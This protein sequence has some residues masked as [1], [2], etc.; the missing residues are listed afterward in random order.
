[1]VYN[2]SN[3]EVSFASGVWCSQEDFYLACALMILENKLLLAPFPGNG[4]RK[5]FGGMFAVWAFAPGLPQSSWSLFSCV[6]LRHTGNEYD[7]SVPCFKA[8]GGEFP[9]R[10][11]YQAFDTLASFSPITHLLL[12]TDRCW[13]QRSAC[14]LSLVGLVD[15]KEYQDMM[16]EALNKEICCH[17]GLW[18][19]GPWMSLLSPWT[20]P[21]F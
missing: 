9:Q 6:C 12:T 2:L 18:G 17:H 7:L 11:Y 10:M 15:S 21:T 4:F 13:G 5:P 3:H 19:G 14:L 8:C 20:T 16:Q 1:M